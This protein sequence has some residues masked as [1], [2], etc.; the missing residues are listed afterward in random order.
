[1]AD[2]GHLFAPF[3]AKMQKAGLPD[4]AVEN[5]K[6]HYRQL[7]DGETGF[8]SERR[9]SPVESLPDSEAFGERLDRLG[10]LTL[11]KTVMVKLNGGLGTGMGLH[12][13]KSLL[14][15]ET[16]VSFLDSIALQ[17]IQLGLPLILMNSFATRGDSL[18]VLSRHSELRQDLPFDFLQHKVPKVRQSDLSP[19]E[20]PGDPELEWCPPG[21]GDIYTALIT[22][23]ILQLLLENDYRYA[24]VSNADNLGAFL[25]P[26]ILGYFVETGTEFLMEAADRTE[27][28][29][30]GG[31]LARIAKG[32]QRLILRESAQCPSED[33]PHFQD[34]NR[35]RYFNTNNLWI[36]L[37]ALWEL[38]RQ[39]ACPPELPLIRNPKT[40]D[41]T[42]PSST[43]VYQLETAMG[44]A[45]SV[46]ENG[47]AI[48]VPRTRFVPVKTCADLLVVRS[49]ATVLTEDFQIVPHP[50]RGESVPIVSL[51]ER[52]YTLIDDLDERFPEGPPSLLHC[53]A[54]S[55][56][57]D[58]G[59]GRNVVVMGTVALQNRTS[60][61]QFVPDGSVLKGTISW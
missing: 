35:H 59:F 24:F 54:L 14:E 3:A 10:I 58:V 26:R 40:A 61:R 56:E 31:H 36:D 19:V 2:F 11:P 28:D 20:V 1:M 60:D 38:M 51:D 33:E 46:F 30:K 42:D 7:V 48:R 39:G 27:A 44:A 37:H 17:S 29:K 15:V 9:L 50:S 47:R 4:L 8:L 18:T 41:P 34:I 16:G 53:E 25:D 32:D 13:A 45:I 22:S 6:G 21:H 52:Y 57:G 23:G 43:P 5:F 12:K 49:D 55:I